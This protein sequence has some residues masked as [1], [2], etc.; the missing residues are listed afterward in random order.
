MKR[1]MDLI[2]EI[3]F[4]CEKQ[5]GADQMI[6]VNIEGHPDQEINYHLVLLRDAGFI[7]ASVLDTQIGPIVQPLRLTWNG[8]EFLNAARSSKL[9]EAAKEFAVKTTGSLTLESLKLAVPHVTKLL[10]GV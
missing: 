7:E 5:D 4:E 6:Q 2:R 10:M 3:L 1:D 9:W 8:H